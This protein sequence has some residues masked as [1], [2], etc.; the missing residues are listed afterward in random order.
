MSP[1]I[2]PVKMTEAQ[3]KLE[4]RVCSMQDAIKAG[5]ALK[6]F[7]E[8]ALTKSPGPKLIQADVLSGTLS[9]VASTTPNADEAQVFVR[10]ATDE[11]HAQ[12]IVRAIELAQKQFDLA[13]KE[14]NQ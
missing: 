1:S 4:R 2:D 6:W 14:A 3:V 8:Y 9:V 11:F 7:A 13:S 5:K 10:Q 12:I